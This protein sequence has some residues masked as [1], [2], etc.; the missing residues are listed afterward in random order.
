LNRKGKRPANISFKT[1]HSSDNSRGEENT[2][3]PAHAD[4]GRDVR[5]QNGGN[6]FTGVASGES[7]KEIEVVR[8][9]MAGRLAETNA[10]R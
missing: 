6:D 2:S 5:S 9:N 10:I 8:L 1:G 4:I 3:T 7:L